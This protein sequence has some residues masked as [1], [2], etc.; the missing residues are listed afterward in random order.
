MGGTEL[1]F[2]NIQRAFPELVSQ[3]QFVLSRPKQVE[4]L[5]KPRILYLQDTAQDP[6]SECLK[7][8]AYRKNFN[9]LVFCSHRQQYEYNIYVGIPYSEGVVIKNSVPL[10]TPT[11]PK[12]IPNGKLKFIYTSTPHRGLAVLAAAAEH[13]AKERQDWELHVYSS[14]NIYGWHDADHQFDEL[15]AQLKKNPC[16]VYHGSVP[17]AEI[18]QAVLDAHVFVYPSIYSEM[19]CMAIQ[20]AM[21][22]GCLV[23]TSGLGALPETCG[24]WA[25]MFP[26]TE[27]MNEMAAATY[28]SMTLALEKYSSEYVQSL[29]PVQSGY[30]QAFY[31]FERRAP[32][33]KSLLEQVIREGTPAPEMLVIG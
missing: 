18:R 24:E 12:P 10:L 15:Y 17:N 7:D 23:I 14:L 13:L 21:M 16:V 25:W 2:A 5:D 27:N 6:E 26:F 9:K 32:V 20:E 22:A 31:S 33:W 11:F 8:P 3:V 19:S 28:N 29:L 1:H 30:Y 4:L